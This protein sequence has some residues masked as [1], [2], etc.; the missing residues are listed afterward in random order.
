L[1]GILVCA[2]LL[3]EIEVD[4]WLDPAAPNAEVNELR[5]DE[6]NLRD[7]AFSRMLGRD[8]CHDPIGSDYI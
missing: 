6:G 8:L 4:N 3:A 1:V 7:I 2:A 5:S